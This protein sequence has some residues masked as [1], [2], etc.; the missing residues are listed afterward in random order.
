MCPTTKHSP[1]RKLKP[2]FFYSHTRLSIV[3]SS[4]KLAHDL[5][6]SQILHAAVDH[7]SE[8][9]KA[10]W[11]TG[12]SLGAALP[13]LTAHRFEYIVG[14]AVEGVHTFG[15]PPVVN[16]HWHFAP[17]LTHQNKDRQPLRWG[18]SSR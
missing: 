11:D 7:L 12:H 2:L 5:A 9:D 8:N 3:H 17:C 15:S 6:C 18:F 4:S 16:R 14:I 1:P 10:L 13:L